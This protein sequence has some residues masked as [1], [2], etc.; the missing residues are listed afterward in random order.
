VIEQRGMQWL[1]PT[2]F[3]KDDGKGNMTIAPLPAHAIVQRS[4]RV[5]STEE[6]RLDR[7]GSYTKR[8]FEGRDVFVHVPFYLRDDIEPVFTQAIYDSWLAAAGGDEALC[9]EMLDAIARLLLFQYGPTAAVLLWGHGNAGKSLTALGLAECISTRRLGDGAALTDNFNDSLRHS[10]IIHVDE[11]LDRGNKGIDGSASLRRI[12]TS[13]QTAIEQ[14][15]KDKVWMQ[16]VHRVLMTANSTDILLALV[17][18]RAR[19]DNDWQ[20]IGERVVCFR[21]DDAAHE[22]FK[23]HNDGWCETSKW[24]GT[25]GRTGLYPKFWMWVLK[26]IVKWRDGRPIMRGKRLLYEGN[27]HQTILAQLQ[28]EAGRVP[29]VAMAINRLLSQHGKSK[30]VLFG[31]KVYVVQQAVIDEVQQRNNRAGTPDVRAALQAMLDDRQPEERLCINGVQQR[32]KTIDAM[33]LYKI[34]CANDSPNK[35]F[36]GLLSLPDAVD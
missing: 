3:S 9:V 12:I 5:Y 18:D 6:I 15:G 4:V 7:R 11:A 34:I 20:A 17:G 27:A 23:K 10:P 22:W 25:H 31:N 28:A 21:L 35:V 8:D 26:N 29:E 16:G 32:W 13:T 2:E 1:V 36:D 30:A 33:R 24:I 14:K 19:T